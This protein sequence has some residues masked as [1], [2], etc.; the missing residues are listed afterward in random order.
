MS[1]MQICHTFHS[2]LLHLNIIWINMVFTIYFD[3]RS[4][5]VALWH[6]WRFFASDEQN[7]ILYLFLTIYSKH[8]QLLFQSMDVWPK[9]LLYLSFICIWYFPKSM[10][11]SNMCRVCQFNQIS[12]FALYGKKN[13]KYFARKIMFT[14]QWCKI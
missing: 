14:R 6:F 11:I 9:A 3:A 10:L 5:N 13:C 1:K 7:Q 4:N 2:S 12:F 8:F